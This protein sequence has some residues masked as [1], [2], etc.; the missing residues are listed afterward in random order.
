MNL[1]NNSFVNIEN[2][3]YGENYQ[4][5]NNLLN[6]AF[7]EL[8]LIKKTEGLE[9]VLTILMTPVKEGSQTG[10]ALDGDMQSAGF[11]RG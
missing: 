11:A 9:I 5:P 1:S 10:V 8:N 6:S 4:Y 2:I 3:E 7:G